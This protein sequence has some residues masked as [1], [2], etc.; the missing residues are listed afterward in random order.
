MLAL[1]LANNYIFAVFFK[2]IFLVVFLGAMHGLFLL[3]VLL[4]L[5]GPGSCTRHD[6]DEDLKLSHIEKSLPHPYCIPHPQF[7]LNGSNLSSTLR[8]TNLTPLENYSKKPFKS[9]GDIDKDLGLG[10]S[11]ENS[12]ES[13][14]HSNKK[15]GI[16]MQTEAEKRYREAWRRNSDAHLN[17]YRPSHIDIYGAEYYRP[18]NDEVLERHNGYVPEEARNRYQRRRYSPPEARTF[19]ASN[20]GLV[21]SSSHHNILHPRYLKESRFP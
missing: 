15:P 16:E 6:E 4:S 10:T 2:M 20:G 1:I 17:Q 12:S 7:T 18:R 9:Y 13:S 8:N 3:P 11:E 14:T 19:P 21:R 5:F